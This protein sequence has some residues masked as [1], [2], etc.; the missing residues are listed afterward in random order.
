MTTTTSPLGMDL[1][2][3]LIDTKPLSNGEWLALRKSIY[4]ASEVS[5]VLEIS[6]WMTPWSIWTNKL[7]IAPPVEVTN[8]ML[9]G[10]FM[11]DGICKWFEHETGLFVVA[12]Q[13]LAY[14]KT[15]S[16]A[17][18]TL[19]GLIVDSPDSPNPIG[20]YEAKTVSPFEDRWEEIP[21]HYQ[22]QGQWQMY[23]TG[24][25]IAKFVVLGNR[26]LWIFELKRDQEDIDFIAERVHD[27]HERYVLT[28]TP[29]P[30]DGKDITLESIGHMWPQSKKGKSIDLS[31][32]KDVIERLL[33]ARRI[34]AEAKKAENAAK[35]EIAV[36]MGD[37]E[38]AIV[39]GE[40]VLTYKTQPDNKFNAKAFKTDHPEIAI[41]YTTP[42]TC[43]VL[44]DK[45]AKKGKK[46]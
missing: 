42:S 7:G 39:D 41:K 11:E 28:Q 17:G 15:D 34:G 44:R 31:N 24:Q 29:P 3:D 8:F 46:K 30:T 22:A 33:A 6:P 20:V 1:P 18:A 32:H 4:G 35:A 19:D 13:H 45:A 16:L 38:S 23:V 25:D 37:A 12:Q 9:Y 2:C 10:T 5:A 27:F 36:L 26:E 40:E 43:R 14:S 21:A